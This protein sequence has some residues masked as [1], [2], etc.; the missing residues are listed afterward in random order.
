M[1]VRESF[2]AEPE[3]SL[4]IREPERRRLITMFKALG[5]PMR[6][7][8]IQFLASHPGSITA[9]V[10]KALPIAQ[11]TVSQHLRALRDA[12]WVSA[13]AEGPA[14]CYWLDA[15]NIRWFRMTVERIF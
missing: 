2:S 11:A 9:D 10:V 6:F 1:K 7:R 5:N 13:E 15:E 14:T 4:D 12:G 3:P 8:I